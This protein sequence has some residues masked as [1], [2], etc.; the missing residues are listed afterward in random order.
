[1]NSPNREKNAKL[2]ILISLFCQLVSI[3]CGL[4]TPRYLLVAFGSEVNG[5]IASI[6]TFLGYIILIEGGIGG[7]ARA[8]LYK[9]LSD[10]DDQK[11][12]EVMSEIKAFFHRVGYVFVLYV[13][14]IACTFNYISHSDALDWTTSFFLVIIISG[15]TFAQYFIGVSN[16]IL[17]NASQRLYI[18]NILSTIV[19]ILNAVAVVLLTINSCDVLT[20]K[21]VSGL[22]F[23][24]KPVAMWLY[25]KKHYNLVPV[26]TKNNVLKDKWTGLGQHIAFFLHNHTDVVVLTIFGNLKLVSIYTVYYMITGAIQNITTS[27]YSGM[28]AVFGDMYAKREV[29]RLNRTFNIYET[30][31]SVVSSVLFGTTLVLIL[32]FVKLYTASIIDTNYIEPLFAILLIGACFL[33]CIRA[34]YHNM[35]IAAGQFRQTNVASYGEA[36]INI[37]SSVIL[38]IR[39]GLIGVAIG[40]VLATLFRFVYYVLYLSKNIL[41]RSIWLCFKREV[42]NIIIIMIIYLIGIRI[43]AHFDFSSYL[44]WVEAGVI[45][46]FFSAVIS[47]LFNITFYKEECIFLAKRIRIK[48][49]NQID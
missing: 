43:A 4:I 17:L 23:V 13:I 35:I 10:N 16:A 12:S 15:S 21:L 28:E 30:L 22:I 38:V 9:P 40:T 31:I 37:I 20:V 26:K 7:V 2:N 27:S 33:Y 14:V 18:S 25:V 41:N 3:I 49:Q 47:L 8:A 6:T 29:A 19:V 42:I 44:I 46:A 39:F 5:A 36:I 48:K 34:P 1:M 11:V 24:V 32:P 45:I